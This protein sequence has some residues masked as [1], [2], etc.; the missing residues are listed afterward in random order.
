MRRTFRS[1]EIRNYRLFFVGQLISICGTWMQTVALGWVVLGLSDDN[2]FAVGLVTA[3][4][5][6]PMLLAGTWAGLQADRYDKRRLLVL[7]QAGMAVVAGALAVVTLSGSAEVWN[8]AVLVLLSGVGNMFDVPARQ[9]FVNELVDR[10]RLP[11]AIGLNS[12]V[13]NGGRIVGPAIAGVLILTAGAGWC[14]VLNALSFV[15]GIVALRR[16]RPEELLR[17]APVVRGGGQIRD[18]LRYIWT[19]P[20]L[21][22]NLVLTGVVGMLAIN[23]PVVLPALAKLT[24]DGNGGTYGA[25]TSAMGVGAL[26][27]ALGVAGRMKPSDRL[28]V[29]AGLGFGALLCISAAAPTL[30][31]LLPLLVLTGVFN[32]VF[33]SSSNTV[34][35]LETAPEM[36]GRVLAVRA[37]LVLG[38][39]PIGGP[40]IGAVC[41]AFGARWGLAVG[42][43]ATVGAALWFWSATRLDRR[44]HVEAPAVDPGLDDEVTITGL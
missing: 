15:A 13:F 32:M 31:A 34:L 20:E 26:V 44:L 37:V 17:S 4:Q 30:G 43:L 12:A 29:G 3:L 35:Q 19:T 21:R 11:N 38:S 27:G 36:R 2:A 23:F 10:E 25:M 40:I 28:L 33:M 24:F 14:F 42:G 6:T 9:S 39:T 22:R 41:A 7:V 16:M 1:L 18:G 5:Y 8:I